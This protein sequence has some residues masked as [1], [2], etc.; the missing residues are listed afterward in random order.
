MKRAIRTLPILLLA[1][2]AVFAVTFL[3]GC[4]DSDFSANVA[5]LEDNGYTVNTLDTNANIPGGTTIVDARKGTGVE[6][7]YVRLY[8][9]NTEDAAIEYYYGTFTEYAV[10][11]FEKNNPDLASRLA[12]RLVGNIVI[13]GTTG[14]VDDVLA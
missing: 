13:F 1:L 11:E 4:V 10:V 3:F 2:T 12:H 9:F 14:G 5:K 7:E 8:Y 6:E